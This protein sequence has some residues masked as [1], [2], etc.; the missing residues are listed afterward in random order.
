MSAVLVA[1]AV[2]ACVFNAKVEVRAPGDNCIYSC[3]RGGNGGDSWYGASA[4]AESR[5]KYAVNVRT[6]I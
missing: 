6:S 4:A 2:C 5:A 3:A 1:V